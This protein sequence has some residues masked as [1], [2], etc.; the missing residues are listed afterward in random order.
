MGG[1]EEELHFLEVAEL[2]GES[3]KKGRLQASAWPTL[4]ILVKMDF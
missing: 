3:N 4:G 2:L 1:A